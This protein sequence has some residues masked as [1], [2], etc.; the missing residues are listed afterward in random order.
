MLCKGKTNISNNQIF[1][2]ISG[3][4][5]VITLFRAYIIS[6]SAH[7][8]SNIHRLQD[9]TSTAVLFIF[10]LRLLLYLN[11]FRI[12]GDDGITFFA[13]PVCFFCYFNHFIGMVALTPS[14]TLKPVL[15][16]T[17][18]SRLKPKCLDTG[19]TNVTKP[20]YIKLL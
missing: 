16:V 3:I 11:I 15:L 6:L 14:P 7:R 8:A 10:C 19:R 12:I 9:V 13:F 1:L 18:K 4:R 17:A 20:P 5:F 2:L